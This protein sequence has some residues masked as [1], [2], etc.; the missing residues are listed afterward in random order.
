MA[1]WC[2]LAPR[3]A[4]GS[5]WRV[6]PCGYAT[7][8]GPRFSFAGVCRRNWACV[9]LEIEEKIEQKV[10]LLNKIIGLSQYI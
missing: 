10:T 4:P 1:T 2:Q 7:K 6:H 8:A 3:I 5:R 9:E